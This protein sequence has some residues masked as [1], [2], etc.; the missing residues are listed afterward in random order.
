MQ[1]TSPN[2]Q[3]K[4]VYAQFTAICQILA[5]L[6]Q[7]RTTKLQKRLSILLNLK[8]TY[9]AKLSQHMRAKKEKTQVLSAFT[10]SNCQ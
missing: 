1:L 9:V 8:K 7:K 10:V 5:T 6:R 4:N 3:E 2:C